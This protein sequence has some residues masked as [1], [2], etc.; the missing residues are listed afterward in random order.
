MPRSGRSRRAG[1]KVI[2]A[3][4]GGLDGR[5]AIDAFFRDRAGP[6]IDA[7]V[8]LTGFSLV[9][10]PA[11]NDS[12]AAVTVLR[13][14]DVPY[15]A[16][17]P[18]EFQTLGQWA[19]QF[20]RAG[21]RRD[22]HADRPARDRRRDLPHRVRRPPRP[23][24]LRGLLQCPARRRTRQMAP[25][26]ERI[27]TL[28]ARAAARPPAS[29]EERRKKV[30]IVLFG[31]PPNAGAV[32][33]AAYLSVFEASSTR[34][35][36]MKADGY[37]VE[38]PDSVEALRVAVLEGNAKQYGQEANVAA[39]VT[40]DEIVAGTPWLKEIEKVWG[41]APGRIQS[42]GRG[43][44]VLGRAIRQGVRRRAADLRL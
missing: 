36:R 39:H 38:V 10:G 16:A 37:D 33:T 13:G 9:G 24:G 20:G 42:D 35:T 8:S 18:L 5:P 11:Y 15:I 4:A 40:A 27:D 1:C 14:L 41:P 44:F 26:L 19:A 43:V 30:G 22:H 28:A 25:C 12:D 3:F 32:G 6:K 34:S 31:F 21:A 2:P 23:R 17:H 7:L 29:R